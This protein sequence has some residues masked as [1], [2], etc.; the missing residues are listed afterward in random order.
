MLQAA[1]LHR[2]YYTHT[3]TH[4]WV[5]REKLLQADKI[6]VGY[7]STVVL[8]ASVWSGHD[9]QKKWDPAKVLPDKWAALL[10]KSQAW[11]ISRHPVHRDNL[12]LGPFGGQRKRK[13]K[14]INGGGASIYSLVLLYRTGA[15][16]RATICHVTIAR[17][18]EICRFRQAISAP[19]TNIPSD[20][21]LFWT[22]N[23]DLGWGS[24]ALPLR[25]SL[26]KHDGLDMPCGYV[27]NALPCF[28]PAGTA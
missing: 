10:N 27:Q 15:A 14:K 2:H 25:T 7:Q 23:T 26:Q 8:A 11:T 28:S 6:I 21:L 1:I 17:S 12:L 13:E 18:S 19:S 22:I 16:P 24:H 3:H 20:A 4:N 5:E 9:K